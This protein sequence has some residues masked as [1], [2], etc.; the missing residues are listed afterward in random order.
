[1]G[2]D[3][4][5]PGTDIYNE[6]PLDSPPGSATEETGY[7]VS[8]RGSILRI[9]SSSPHQNPFPG[10]AYL[11]DLANGGAGVRAW[12][13][14]CPMSGHVFEYGDSIRIKNGMT[15]GPVRQGFDNLI[16]QDPSAYWGTGPNAPAGGCVFRSGE[17]D[18]NGDH[19]C[20]AS[21]RVRAMFLSNPD[22][23]PSSPGNDKDIILQNFVGVFVI[24]TG[25][26]NGDNATCHGNM[27]G[28]GGGVWVRFIDY[29]GVNVAPSGNK[30]G[31][32]VR[33]LQLIE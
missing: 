17:V 33:V 9:Y 1:L 21:P 11:L 20:V 10:W 12:I 29:R 19:V 2:T 15:V 3:Q 22:E 27:N 4:W 13:E 5:D 32:L 23:V 28:A 14:G 30:T 25:I 31:S 26:L 16:A 18:Q 24:C 7:G 8:D 6:G